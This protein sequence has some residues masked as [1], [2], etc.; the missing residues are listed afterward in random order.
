MPPRS[1]GTGCQWRGGAGRVVDTDPDGMATLSA[2]AGTYSYTTIPITGR[3]DID[4]HTAT[5]F[6][7]PALALANYVSTIPSGANN[8]AVDIRPHTVSGVAMADAQR[9]S[10][11]LA[12]GTM[13]YW[14][15]RASASVQIS[16][17]SY[18]VPT[19]IVVRWVGST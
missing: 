3:Y 13:L 6:G 8:V 15:N 12:A 14:S 9:R 2:A 16:A 11:N 18:V 17:A 7:G 19:H 5:I 1:S 4:F 10:V